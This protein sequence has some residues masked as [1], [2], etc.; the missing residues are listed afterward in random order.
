MYAKVGAHS[1][2]YIDDSA[3]YVRGLAKAGF[4]LKITNRYKM[5]IYREH[6]TSQKGMTPHVLGIDQG[7]TLSR[8]SD[9]HFTT[10][11]ADGNTFGQLSFN[12][13]M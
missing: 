11:S 10:I 5:H 2:T 7:L 13:Y 1:A 3:S 4:L 12:T 9:L 8:N 6:F